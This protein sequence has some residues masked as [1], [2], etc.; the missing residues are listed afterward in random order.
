[1]LQR[2]SIRFESNEKT[3]N[4]MPLGVGAL[5]GNRFGINRTK[6]A[7]KL[8]FTEI[9]K[10]SIDTVSDRDFVTDVSYSCSMLAV[11]L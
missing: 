4:Q 1:M 11:H 6:L 5:A 8:G 2:D 9:T 3:L 10:N 7:K